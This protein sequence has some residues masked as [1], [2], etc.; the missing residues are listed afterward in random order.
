MINA[1]DYQHQPT[2]LTLPSGR[3]IEA[4]TVTHR[5]QRCLEAAHPKPMPPMKRKPGGSLAGEA[6]D[7]EDPAYRD[8]F[9]AW[10]DDDTLLRAAIITGY[11]HEGLGWDIA[12]GS[13]E[14][15]AWCAGVIE[16]LGALVSAE[17][18]DAVC[19]AVTQSELTLLVR[20]KNKGN[21][22]SPSPAT[23]G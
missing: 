11:E 2:K 22:G 9:N 13:T 18:A 10:I 12:R 6:P 3:V 17:W 7:H 4:R 8:A 19:R 5:D 23:T 21:S 14:A 15:P 1:T 20:E 16:T